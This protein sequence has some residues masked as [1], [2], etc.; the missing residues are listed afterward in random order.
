MVTKVTIGTLVTLI[1]LANVTTLR[2]KCIYVFMS[3]VLLL[4][5][6]NKTGMCGHI[7]VAASNIILP[8][9]PSGESRVVPCWHTHRRTDGRTYT[10]YMTMATVAFRSWFAK[11]SKTDVKMK[12]DGKIWIDLASDRNTWHSCEHSSVP[13]G[14]T[15]RG[16]SWHAKRQ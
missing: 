4:F 11:T 9:N 10:A 15:R 12:L 13:S 1:T 2:H 3:S 6:C 5:N 7:L 8:V 14:S 16:M